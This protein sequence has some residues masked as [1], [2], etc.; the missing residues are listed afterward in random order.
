MVV[1]SDSLHL[2]EKFK[3]VYSAGCGEEYDMYN[4]LVPRIF[5]PCDECE[6]SHYFYADWVEHLAWEWDEVIDDEPV[7]E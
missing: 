3:V 2:P 5:L 6:E 1:R 4:I 7:S